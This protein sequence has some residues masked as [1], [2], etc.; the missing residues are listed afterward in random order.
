MHF[1]AMYPFNYTNLFCIDHIYMQI[2]A[3]RK[4]KRSPFKFITPLC[5]ILNMYNL[6]LLGRN[7]LQIHSHMIMFFFFF[8]KKIYPCIGKDYKLGLKKI[9]IK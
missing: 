5:N 1:H 6:Y 2:H 7:V 4:Y 8:L 9:K 3:Y